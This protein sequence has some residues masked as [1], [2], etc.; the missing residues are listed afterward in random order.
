MKLPKIEGMIRRR[1]LVNFRI[2]PE[3]MQRQLPGRFRPKLHAG[4]AIGGIC[5]IRLEHIRPLGMPA[6]LGLNSENAAHR[7]AVFWEDEH[8]VTKEGVF[9][10]RRDTDSKLNQLAGGRVFPGEHHAA[11]FHVEA[12]GERINLEMKSKDGEVAVRVRGR[13]ALELPAASGFGTLDEASRFFEPGSLGYSVTADAARL[14]GLTLKTKTWK[15]DAL[16]VEQV[17]SSYFADETK[18]PKGSVDFDCALL[19]RDIEHEW[20]SAPDL[21]V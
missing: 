16:E 19:M 17:F 10:P 14:D 21:Y 8:G 15:V 13:V 6:F 5:L 1:I 18:F 2:A 9:I 7:I 12:D 4:K 20:H 3:V 11:Q